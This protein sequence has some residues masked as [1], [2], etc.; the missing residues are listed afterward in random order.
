MS[1]HRGALYGPMVL[2]L[3]CKD[4]SL[5]KTGWD[6]LGQFHSIVHKRGSMSSP[7]ISSPCLSQAHFISGDASKGTH[8]IR[9]GIWK[10]GDMGISLMVRHVGLHPSHSLFIAG[11]Q[12]FHVQVPLKAN[13]SRESLRGRTIT[14]SHKNN[15]D[16]L[17][18]MQRSGH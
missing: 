3:Q 18:Q 4:H 10:V 5:C 14:T 7:V 12:I 11:C 13:E 6:R 1:D 17:H 16:P 9:Q 8:D 2:R 15:I